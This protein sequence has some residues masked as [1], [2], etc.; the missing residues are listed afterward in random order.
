M[1]HEGMESK[2][3]GRSPGLY[4][5]S[6][7]SGCIETATGGTSVDESEPQPLQGRDMAVP[8]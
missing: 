5:G 2:T 4:S 7:P 6:W 1:L 8:A 3:A